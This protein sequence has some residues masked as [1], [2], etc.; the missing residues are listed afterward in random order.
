MRSHVASSAA[1]VVVVIEEGS[2]GYR[3]TRIAEELQSNRALDPSQELGEGAAKGLLQQLVASFENERPGA[4]A[5]PCDPPH[6][7]EYG[8]VNLDFVGSGDV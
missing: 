1:A 6:L 3:G 7:V 4:A 5:V 2:R 8:D